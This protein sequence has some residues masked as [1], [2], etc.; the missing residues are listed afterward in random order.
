MKKESWNI[1]CS[2]TE[3]SSKTKSIDFKQFTLTTF[4]AIKEAFN[5]MESS[6]ILSTLTSPNLNMKL[7]DFIVMLLRKEVIHSEL[8]NSSI[9]HYEKRKTPHGE[10]LSPLLRNIA[11]SS[12]EINGCKVIAYTDDLITIPNLT[13]RA[14]YINSL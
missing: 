10:V 11:I 5:N 13:Q 9:T 7:I 1:S 8:R 4:L 12:T 6:A 14:F 3:D 2:N